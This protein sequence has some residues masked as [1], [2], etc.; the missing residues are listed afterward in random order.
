[1]GLPGARAALDEAHKA[2]TIIVDAATVI[3]ASSLASLKLKARIASENGADLLPPLIQ[4][5]LSDI[6][7]MKEAQH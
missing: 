6:L 3:A 7:T 1:M 2:H 4:S 5:I